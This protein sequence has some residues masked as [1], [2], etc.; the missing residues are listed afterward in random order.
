MTYNIDTCNILCYYFDVVENSPG[1][2]G[3]GVGETSNSY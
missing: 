3:L 1:P 2:G